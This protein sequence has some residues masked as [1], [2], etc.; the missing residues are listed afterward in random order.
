MSERD[1][2]W[3]KYVESHDPTVREEIILQNVPL[4][5]HI[6]S[7]LAIPV[8]SEEAYGDL[9]SQ[10]ILG[11]ID[12]VDRFEPKRGW[13]FSTYASLRIRGHI[14]DALRS[15]DV[16][17]RGARK[18]VKGIESSVSR[19]RMELRREP[20]EREV[21]AAANLDLKSYRAALVEAN[22]AVLSI[23]A[24]IEDDGGD[25]ALSLRDVLC[26]HD[27]PNPEEAVEQIELEQRLAAALH[28]LPRRLQVLLA[29]YYYEGLT[30]KEVG[31][32]LELSESRVSQL[33]AHA[34]KQLRTALEPSVAFSN[35]VLEPAFHHSAS[36][37]AFAG[38]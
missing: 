9:V 8:L 28:R 18:R 20:S 23:D 24:V 19:L 1:E 2:L 6:L 13:R 29:L 33:H 38:G 12:A 32:V 21:A 26:D 22:C 7:R 31:L 36:V 27:A 4:V 10:G 30:M 34:M 14:L 3:E 5:R 25:N 16:L 37:P 11:L 15:M 17:P 35:R